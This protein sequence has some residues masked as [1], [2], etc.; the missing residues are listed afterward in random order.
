MTKSDVSLVPMPTLA[1]DTDTK[2][3]VFSLED[4]LP[5]NSE[6]NIKVRK[7]TNF[8]GIDLTQYKIIGQHDTK[9]HK[10]NALYIK[11]T[12]TIKEKKT[13]KLQQLVADFVKHPKENEYTGVV[14]SVVGEPTK[15]TVLSKIKIGTPVKMNKLTTKDDC[16]AENDECVEYWGWVILF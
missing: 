6:T 4:S 14:T 9:S 15:S 10:G 1:K 5:K 2:S 12:F 16:N 3:V 11:S 8:L 7:V 13:R